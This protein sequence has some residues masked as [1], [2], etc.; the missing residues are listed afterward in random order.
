MRN[1]IWL[2]A[3]ALLGAVIGWELHQI[4][5]DLLN[6]NSGDTDAFSM[7]FIA[8]ACAVFAVLGGGM[9]TD[10]FASNSTE[11]EKSEADASIN[12]AEHLVH[13]THAQ[14]HLTPAPDH[15]T[16]TPGNLLNA[17]SD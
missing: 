15:L 10:G 16:H 6:A 8:I 5:S 2:P 12:I 3:I 7:Q 9:S 4:G 1:W 14:N 17:P 11:L 13:L